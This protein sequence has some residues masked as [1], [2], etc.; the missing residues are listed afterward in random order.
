MFAHISKFEKLNAELNVK[1][2]NAKRLQ[3]EI[4]KIQEE[5]DEANTKYTT[6]QTIHDESKKK[7]S[8]AE[9]KNSRLSEAMRQ[10]YIERNKAQQEK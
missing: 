9:N 1:T 10:M 2:Q 8:D 4:D 6:E 7:L 5:F 3:N